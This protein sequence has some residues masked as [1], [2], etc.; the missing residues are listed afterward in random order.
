MS[1]VRFF[2]FGSSGTQLPGVR[3]EGRQ[4][5][6]ATTTGSASTGA[7][8]RVSEA[9]VRYRYTLSATLR[10]WLNEDRDLFQFFEARGGMM[11]S[12]L[13]TDPW[14]GVERRVRFDDDALDLSVRAG[15][16]TGSF[17]LVTVI[18]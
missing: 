11:D 5:F 3:V 6:F 13:F 16:W 12:F 10:S 9:L 15:V 4:P 8:Y 14:D 18:G 1:N 17:D 2:T 7:E